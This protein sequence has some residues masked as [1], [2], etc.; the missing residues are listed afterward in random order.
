M[1]ADK[2]AEKQ[3]E[4]CVC[5]VFSLPY[6]SFGGVIMAGADQNLLELFSHQLL[7]RGLLQS[8]T[9]T[10]IQE[11]LERVSSISV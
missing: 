8:D 5:N 9:N 6:R 2:R 10:P 7:I 3:T 1:L 4:Q 11:A